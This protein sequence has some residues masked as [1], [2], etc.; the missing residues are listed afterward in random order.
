MSDEP[1]DLIIIKRHSGGDHDS[2]HGGVWKIAFADFMTAMMCFFLVMWLIN[3]ANE[4]TRQAV[5]S[6]FNPVR[7]AE[8]NRKGLGDPHFT[9]E[10]ARTEGDSP[11]GAKGSGDAA[12]SQAD[13]EHTRDELFKDPYKV[14]AEIAGD[15]NAMPSGS[16]DGAS[17]DSASAAAAYRDP[18]G[19]NPDAPIVIGGYPPAGAAANKGKGEGKADTGT[20]SSAPE[21]ASETKEEAV[22]VKPAPPS[23]GAEST[24]A[25][26]PP[27]T[28]D[29]AP[30]ADATEAPPRGEPTEGAAPPK[31]LPP[32]GGATA[33]GAPMSVPPGAAPP[34]PIALAMGVPEAA[35]RRKEDRA[36]LEKVAAEINNGAGGRGSP[37]VSVESTGEGVLISMTDDAHFGMFAIGSAEPQPETIRVMEQI[38]AALATQPGAIIIRGHT[39]A[40]PFRGSGYDNWQLST[41]R[42]QIAYR[43]LIRGGLD[44]SRVEAIEGYADRQLKVPSDPEAAENRR[45]EI[46]VREPS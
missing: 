35:A 25:A 4:D 38:A 45:I 19:P 5:A 10:A 40:R 39:D 6:Y 17:G 26:A 20:S 14:L 42:A 22:A 13:P 36:R 3:A 12:P 29:D 43:M 9:D 21:Q 30:A 23:A 2:V 31:P 18:F 28:A 46:L 37:K 15:A 44:A 7:L 34:Q 24:A 1:H 16:G 11:V 32:T 8:L 33:A 41:D 27:P